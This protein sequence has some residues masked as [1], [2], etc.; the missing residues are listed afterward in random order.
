MAEFK[1]GRLR[2]TW[3]G[4]WQTGTFYNRDAVV[5][6]NGKA[7]ICLVPH[8][9]TDFYDGLYF[10]TQSGASTPYWSLM[11]DGK[12]WK[13]QWL[14]NTAYSLGNIVSYGGSVYQCTTDH[15][16]GSSVIDLSNWSVT[17]RADNF[18][19]DWQINT[20]YGIGDKVKYGGI[21]YNCKTNHVSAASVALGLEDNQSAW[22]VFYSGIEYKFN[23][24]TGARYKLNDVVKRNASLWIATSGHTSASSFDDT[25]WD[26]WLPGEEYTEAWDSAISYQVGDLVKYGGYSYVSTSTNNTNNI[27]SVDSVNWELVTIGY[28]MR[29]EWSDA[30]QYR[31]GD[32]VRRSGMLFAAVADNLSADPSG[33]VV[34]TNYNATGSSGTTVVVT[35]TAG[36]VPG[37]LVLGN[38]FSLQ[39]TVTKVL[40]STTLLVSAAPDTTPVDTLELKFTGVSGNYWTVI[41]PSSAWKNRWADSEEYVVGDIV[42]WGNTTYVCVA[43]HNSSDLLRPDTDTQNEIYWQIYTPHFRKNAMN[44]VGDL[45]TFNNGSYAPVAVPTGYFDE[46]LRVNNTL[47]NWQ[48]INVVP[49][50]YYVT[51]NGTDSV[52]HGTTW[53]KPWKTIKYACEYIGAGTYYTGSAGLLLQNRSFLVEEVY[54]WMLYQVAEENAPFTLSSTFDEEKTKRDLKLVIDAIAYDIARGGNSQVV[55]ATTAYFA[56]EN[57]NKFVNAGVKADMPY[58]LASLAYLNSIIPDVISNQTITT[59][60][61]SINVVTNPVLQVY[62]SQY[63]SEPGAAV[64]IDSLYNIL[65]N[66]LAAE[67]K[68]LIPLPNQ[69]LTATIMVKTGTYFETLPI[70]VPENVALVGDELRGAVVVPATTVNTLALGV[71]SVTNR[72]TLASY[73]DVSAGTPIQFVGT[74]GDSYAGVDTGHTVY[75]IDVDL[76]YGV[77]V[78]ESVNGSPITL[79]DETTSITVYGGD[80]IKDMFYVRNASGIRNMT[81]SG[82]LGTLSAPNQF[83]TQRPTGGSF[84]SLDPGTGPD[85]SSAWIIRRSP[86]IQNVTNFGKGCVGAKIDGRLHNGGLKSIVANDFTQI[87]SDGIGVWCTGPGSLT[88]LVSVFA[89]YGY[90][91]YMAEDGGRIRAT[92]GNTSYGV[93]GV[94]AEGFD[95]TEAPVTG[96]V[97]NRSTQVQASVQSS[98]GSNAKL[99]SLQFANSG[100][101]Y[102]QTTTN[103][104]KQSNHFDELATWTTDGNLVL[105]QNLLAPNGVA[106]AWTL[107]SQS[108]TPGA[109][110]ISQ[111]VSI[112]PAGAVYTNVP[113]INITGSGVN[114]TFDIT[115]TS[116]SYIVTV[117]NGG[118]GYVTNNTMYIP[119]SVLG[120]ANTTNDCLIT[121]AALAGSSILTVNRSGTVPKGSD[122]SYTSSVYVKKG[123]ATTIALSTVFTG[124]VTDSDAGIVFDFNTATIT[125]Y[126]GVNGV[127]P[128]NY[129]K[130]TLPDGWYRIW[131]ATHDATGL[132]DTLVYSLLP[133]GLL[134]TAAYSYVYGTQVELSSPTYEP[135]FYL[136]TTTNMFTSH[137]NFNIQGAGT[138]AVLIGDELRSRAVF[139]TRVT[140]IGSGE[141][142]SG[143]LTA[144]NAAQGGT[145]QYIILSGSD[146][147]T[148]SNYDGM[149]VFINSG[150]GAGQY[151]FI[152]S[153][154]EELKIAQV[155]KESFE[156]LNVN[157]TTTGL[158]N[159]GPGLTTESMYIDQPIQFIPTAY[160]N[161]ITSVGIDSIPVTGILGGTVNTFTVANT[162]RLRLN[163]PVQFSGTVVGGV[164][165]GYTYYIQA[166]LSSTTFRISTQLGGA[167]WQLNTAT[168]TA[169]TMFIDFPTNESYINGSTTSMKPNMPVQFT[170]SSIGGINVGVKYYVNEV[171]DSNTFSIASSVTALT[172]TDTNTTDDTFTVDSTSNLVMFNPI[173]FS[174]TVFGNVV[175]DTTYYIS[176]IPDLNTFTVVSSMI[177]TSATASELGSNL[178]TVTSTAGFIVD[179]PIKFIGTAFGDIVSERIY[180]I[181]V[182]NDATT[183]TISATPGGSAVNLKDAVG[184]M[185][186]KTTPAPFNLATASGSMTAT[187]TSSKLTLSA[188]YGSM[189]GTYKSSLFG[190][191]VEGTTY[192]VVSLPGSSSFAI[193]ETVS[194]SP[195]A[196]EAKNGS[197]DFGEVGWD[198]IN[199]GTAIETPLDSSSVYYI[200]PKTTYDAPGFTQTATTGVTLASGRSWVSIAY[201]KNKWMALPSTSTTGAVSTN[202]TTWTSITLPS[203]N[204]WTNIAYG[205]GY[206]VALGYDG[207]NVPFAA[208]S[209]SEGAGWRTASMPSSAVIY[210]PIAY[211][212]G[213][214]VALSTTSSACAYSVDYGKT[215]IAGSGLPSAS[216]KSVT[217]G[218]GKFVAVASGGTT[219]AYSTDGITWTSV[220]LPNS[221]AWAAIVYG[222]GRYVVTASTT[223]VTLY[224]FD[225]TTWYESHKQIAASK[226]A[227]G[228]GVFVALMPN[229]TAGFTSEDGMHWKPR[230][231]TSSNYGAIAFGYS[232]STFVGQFLTLAGLNTGSA[233]FAGCRAKGRAVIESGVITSVSQF[234]AG[235]N[236]VAEPN[237]SFTDPNVTTLATT[238]PRLGNGS[239]GNPTFYNRGTG[240]STSSTQIAITGSGY[241]DAYQTG[242][243]IIVK[244]LTKLPQPGDNL[245]ID[246]VTQI[247]KITSATAAFG[248]TA[249]SIEANIQVA[250]SIEVRD[251]PDEGAPVTI[252]QKYSQVRLTGHD[253]L[254]VGYGDQLESNYPGLPVDTVLAPQDQAVEVNYGR[255]FYTSTDQDGNFKVG[256]LFAVEQAT[257]IVTLSASQFG[258]TGLDTISLGGIAVGGQSVVIRQFSTDA[259]FVAN[260]NEIIPT[261]K[262]I[263]S[264]LTG[265]LSQGGSNTFTGQLIAGTVLVGGADKISST[266]PEGTL[267]SNVQMLNKVMVDGPNAA[268]AGDGAAMAFFMKTWNHR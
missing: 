113:A 267:G 150:T 154:N 110:I 215:W 137:A 165:S 27:P 111:D 168:P 103:M 207:S 62:D 195:L 258:L 206:W 126:A 199:P 169:S 172:V 213:T 181:L 81:L 119:G 153:Y 22:E 167:V 83:T 256:G 190:N 225:A 101:A 151:G 253:F 2:F 216:W 196:L 142:G 141:G 264:Y 86:Y 97:Y 44:T 192:Y 226:L 166:I 135:S 147:N 47:P 183:F 92:N 185:I 246:G 201:G 266:I 127:L 42:V 230:V 70:T 43:N 189:I 45:E 122:L 160:T 56:I 73:N 138:G 39:Q 217:Y 51:P 239:L 115:V 262:A 10:V 75:V 148:A 218:N 182:V 89:Y 180:Y 54:Q 58:I 233:I 18:T 48:R 67:D 3:K 221:G 79:T 268:W 263:K 231:V 125:P 108:Q 200:E 139:Q 210:T 149:R 41:A 25:K 238:T 52:D 5:E 144:S 251:S 202:G 53:D 187:T 188:G 123:T 90:A 112:Q 49:D 191:V 105:Q 76:N 38:G 16:S 95:D 28:N 31:V 21:V 136:E 130:V 4:Q 224:S 96:N 60:Y 107:T 208:Y 204:V 120:G 30:T 176:S 222:K 68:N 240:Y 237:I 243:T 209:N 124:G 245:V 228:Q 15:T 66:A 143:Y 260:S 74:P 24:T 203:A 116:S 229:S 252:R 12:S 84:V 174:G 170:G 93:Y 82:L 63:V 242:L 161:S 194:G 133:S 164:I 106:E 88:E 131:V 65:N 244:N 145:D 13:G 7:Y 214:F 32:V 232:A 117:N 71:S 193:S 55:A 175:E 146:I 132:N 50:V 64:E 94:I 29:D 250:P 98:F 14:P 100:S 129:G 85:D 118:S 157:S 179:N 36:I 134:G 227:Y 257:G 80:A 198:H 241:A 261:Q 35:D 248:T 205:N 212:N 178:I 34:R 265:R 128:T 152:S 162:R 99:L 223:D 140:D 33:A 184:E 235:S 9:S 247:Y 17:V 197:M 102:D 69:G 220:T 114:A 109:N 57:E 254:N 255:V 177:T 20:A 37:M 155:L 249:P 234:E 173:V 163:Q 46:V 121:V 87:L 156:V 72:I 236:Y 211:G 104:L 11:L 171:V 77:I 8:T 59:L 23:W 1:I 19:N 159:L 26:I 6:Y 61:Q 158:L 219:A 40:N 186:V 91:G 259:T 78:S